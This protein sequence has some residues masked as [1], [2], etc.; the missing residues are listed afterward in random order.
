MQ[1]KVDELCREARFPGTRMIPAPRALRSALILKL[2]GKA[3]RSHVMDLLFDPGIALADRV[4][5]RSPNSRSM[6]RT[7]TPRWRC[8][9]GLS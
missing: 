6:P 8:A 2:L 7:L 9:C 5:R 3:R 1:L 4:R